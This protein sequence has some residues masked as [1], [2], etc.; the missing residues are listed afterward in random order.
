[1]LGLVLCDGLPLGRTNDRNLMK[2]TPAI[3]SAIPESLEEGQLSKQTF[4]FSENSG[5][6]QSCGMFADENDLET[7][8]KEVYIQHIAS[9]SIAATDGR[10]SQ[11]DVLLQV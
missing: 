9:D 3:A 11:G 7:E 8:E 6:I 4:E 1:M 5:E 10:L 2:L